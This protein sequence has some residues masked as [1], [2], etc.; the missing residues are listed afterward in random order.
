MGYLTMHVAGSAVCTAIIAKKSQ[1]V[2]TAIYNEI[3]KQS[4][5][6]ARCKRIKRLLSL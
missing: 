3:K 1:D 2:D 5:V 6:C 4:P